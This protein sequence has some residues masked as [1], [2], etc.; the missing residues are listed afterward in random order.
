MNLTLVQQTQ[1]DQYVFPY[2]YISL[3]LEEYRRLTHRHYLSLLDTARRLLGELAGIRVLDVGCG[4]GRFCY[5]LLQGGATS[6]TGL[7][8]SPRAIAFARAFNPRGR[9]EVADPR[10]WQPSEPMDAIACL[11]VIEHIPISEVHGFV[12]AVCAAGR[13]GSRLVVSVPSTNVPLPRKHYQHFTSKQLVELFSGL[14][15][16]EDII[17]HLLAGNQWRRFE[18]MR[19]LSLAL[20]R[21]RSRLPPINALVEMTERQFRRI[22]FC[23]PDKARGI[24]ALFRK[25]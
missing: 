14:C 12:R 7:D 18:R 13:P 9:F 21:L 15:Q 16:P 1:E 17:G 3:Y 11:E 5:E 25:I 19:R 22:E 24:I 4:D 23:D 2:H 8:Y 10:T 20:W 6:V